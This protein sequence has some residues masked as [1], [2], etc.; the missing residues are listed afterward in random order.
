M[1]EKKAIITGITGQD[2]AYLAEFL[3]DQGYTVIGILH[4][5]R[6]SDLYRL[7]YLNIKDKVILKYLD[8]TL[9]DANVQF[10]STHRPDEIYHL[11]GQSSVAE[12]IR[13]PYVT[14]KFNIDSILNLLEAVRL[15]EYNVRVYYSSSS[16]IF[17]NASILPVTENTPL[18][19]SNPY[20]LSKATGYSLVKNYREL[21]HL[22]AVCGIVFNHESYLRPPHFFVKKIIQS[23][24]QISRGQLDHV[25]V[26]NLDIRRDFGYAREYVRAFWHMLQCDVPQDFIISSGVSISLSEIVDYVFKK[27]GVDQSKVIRDAGLFRP[28]DIPDMVGDPS[29]ILRKTKWTYTR[30]FYQVLDILLDEEMKMNESTET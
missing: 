27:L 29:L 6:A 15:S 9:L 10:I 26:G 22:H 19:P 25:E 3:L 28:A 20:A 17:G 4:P 21:Y 30:S 1:I 23:A 13:D 8:M 11:S 16:E 5:G 12:S 14:L 18:N 7:K 24:V 2:G